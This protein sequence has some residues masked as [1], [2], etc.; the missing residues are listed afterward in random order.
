MQHFVNI[1]R[2]NKVRKTSAKCGRQQIIRSSPQLT[3][4]ALGV[5]SITKF[6]GIIRKQRLARVVLHF[7]NISSVEKELGELSFSKFSVQNMSNYRY[8]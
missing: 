4:A 3:S 8:I 2:R 6:H 1:Y 5:K 7:I